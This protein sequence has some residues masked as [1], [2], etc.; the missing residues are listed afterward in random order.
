MSR[1]AAARVAAIIP[2]RMG[3]SRFPGKPLLQVRGVPMVEHVRRR[4][5]LS[6]AF[7]SVVVATCDEAIAEVVERHG[8]TV[9][10]TSPLHQ[11]ATDRVAEAMTKVECTHV[12][13]VQGD[14]I[15]VLP[16]DLARM[17]AAIV[18]AP[19]TA[20][21]NAIGVIE[22]RAELADSSIVKC[23]ISRSRRIL[24]CSRDFSRLPVGDE[25][26]EP[27]RKI[28]GILAYRRDFLERYGQLAR[29]PLERAESIDQSRII[30][31]DVTLHGVDFTC[32]YPGINEPR[33]VALVERYLAEDCRQQA[34]LAD[35]LRTGVAGSG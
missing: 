33:E 28:L 25:A 27:V 1:A 19:E 18:A 9:L 2:A 22:N 24:F 31:H 23:V 11:A 12:V 4:A 6:G 13:N 17:V 21:W 16:E 5:L 14:E 15:L 8:G 35:V 26:F 29:T 20:A 7:A 32:G 30:E 10:M 3:S 34:V